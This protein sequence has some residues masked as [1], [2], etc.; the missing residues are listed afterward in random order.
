MKKLRIIVQESPFLQVW[1]ELFPVLKDF[2]TD[3]NYLFF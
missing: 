3:D 2:E 1:D